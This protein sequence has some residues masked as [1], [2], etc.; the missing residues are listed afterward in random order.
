MV[1]DLDGFKHVNDTLGHHH[2]DVLLKLVGERLVA[3]LRD[4]DTVARLGGDEFGVLL[5]TGADL[6]GV[7]TVVWKIRQA[8]ERAVRRRWATASSVGIS[9][10]ITLVPLH[11]DNI[12]DL[13]RRADLAMYDAKRSG[14]GSRC[15]RPS[16]RRRPPAA[17]R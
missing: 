6:A 9:I 4:S 14:A 8:F 13:L 17:W 3:C 5:P 7:A 16:R 1:L 10:G 15:S 11:G 2:G 12:D